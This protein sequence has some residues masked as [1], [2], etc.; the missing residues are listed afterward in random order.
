MEKKI[1]IEIQ[2]GEDDYELLKRIC[3]IRERKLE[4]LLERILHNFIED[5]I[6]YSEPAHRKAPFSCRCPTMSLVT[7]LDAFMHSSSQYFLQAVARLGSNVTLILSLINNISN[8]NYL[9]VINITK[10]K[11]KSIESIESIYKFI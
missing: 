8:N 4:E 1:W 3:E 6:D 5:A 10:N 2:M 7:S 9:N 11:I